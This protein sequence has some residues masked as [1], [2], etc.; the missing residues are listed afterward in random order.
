MDLLFAIINVGLIVWVLAQ[1]GRILSF[2]GDFI[3]APV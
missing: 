2:V 3:H 1:L